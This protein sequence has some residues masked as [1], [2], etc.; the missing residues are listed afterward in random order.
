VAL[1]VLVLA[2]AGCER[3]SSWPGLRDVE[4]CDASPVQIPVEELGDFFEEEQCDPFGSGVLFPDG[5]ELRVTEQ[6]HST[7]AGPGI[8]Q[9][10]GTEYFLT[11]GGSYGLAAAMRL[12]GEEVQ[13]FGSEAAIE[14]VQY[15]DGLN[16]FDSCLWWWPSPD[17]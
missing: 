11:N 2:V 7:V 1:V 9:A 14:K 4:R 12:P 17:C 16:P 8:A 6:L 15:Q 5:K 3:V 13:W 10:D